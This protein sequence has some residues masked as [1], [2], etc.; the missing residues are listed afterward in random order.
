MNVTI[1]SVTISTDRKDFKEV[2]ALDIIAFS[3]Q[4]SRVHIHCLDYA[5]GLLRC[6]KSCRLRWI[7]YLRPDVKR[8]N[9][10]KE[11]EET[12]IR[13]HETLGNK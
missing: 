11:E 6:G 12:I 7:N 4:F 1:V 10:T 8:G 9:F 5:V 2:Y 13:L 3:I